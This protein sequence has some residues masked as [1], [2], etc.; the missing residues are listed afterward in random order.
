MIA[1]SYSEKCDIWSLGV[2]LYVMVTAQMPFDGPDDKTILKNI[3]S[4]KFTTESKLVIMKF[5]AFRQ[6]TI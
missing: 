5:Q 2:V 4:S 6:V 1:N 3:A